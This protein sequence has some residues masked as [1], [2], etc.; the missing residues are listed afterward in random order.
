MVLLTSFGDFF[1]DPTRG[2]ALNALTDAIITIGPNSEV[3]SLTFLKVIA[4]ECVAMLS[5]NILA[6]SA[7]AALFAPAERIIDNPLG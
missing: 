7:I 5:A 4:I 2:V 6:G 1:A 3:V